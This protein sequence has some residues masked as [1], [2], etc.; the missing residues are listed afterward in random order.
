MTTIPRPRRGTPVLLGLAGYAG[1]LGLLGVLLAVDVLAPSLTDP[2]SSGRELAAAPVLDPG[3]AHGADR[4]AMPSTAPPAGLGRT[5]PEQVRPFRPRQVVLPS[6]HGAPVLPVSVRSDGS[7]VVPD[8]PRKVGWWDGGALVGDPYGSVVIAGHVDSARY[9]VGVLAGLRA[10]EVGQVLQV[11]AGT[12][13]MRYRIVSRTQ[14]RQ[15]RLARDTDIFRR[16]VAP[17]LVVI[18]CGGPFNAVTHRYRDNL[19]VVA[20]PLG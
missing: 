12:R 11:R 19:V 17:R 3:V 6:G 14:V 1:V 8:D 18:T 20:T 5:A 2:R 15:A 9:G 7:L 13:V 4:S 10:T 16:D